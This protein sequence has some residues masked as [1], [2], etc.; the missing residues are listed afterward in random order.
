MTWLTDAL[1]RLRPKVSKDDLIR[2][3]NAAD[4]L[5]KDEAFQ[6]AMDAAKEELLTE[7]LKTT[8]EQGPRREEISRAVRALEC[9]A[10]QLERAISSGAM[11]TREQRQFKV[12]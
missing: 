6:A 2:R 10:S 4:R 3:G 9:V 1:A 12:V 5:M 7:W 11:E 8:P